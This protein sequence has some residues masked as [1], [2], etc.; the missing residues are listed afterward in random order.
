MMA[1]TTEADAAEGHLDLVLSR[2]I[3]APPSLIWKAFIDPDL[4]KRW[5]APA[6]WTTPECQMDVRPGGVF[7]TVMRAP[8]GSEYPGTGCFLDIVENERIVFT[9][10]LAAGWRPAEK[11]FFTAIITL[12]TSE[13]GTRYTARA[14]HKNEADREAHEKMGFHDGWGRCAD[15]LARLVTQMK[16]GA[17]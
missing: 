5:W 3:E 15:Q 6:P 14:L 2:T 17:R 4:L 11:P 13:A 9:D 12:E 10:A 7:R 16:E 1:V 8:D